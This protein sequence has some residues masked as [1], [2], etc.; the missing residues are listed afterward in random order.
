MSLDVLDRPQTETTA[1]ARPARPQPQ[2]IGVIDCDCHPT[3]RTIADLKPYLARRWWERIEAYGL[4]PRHAFVNGDPFPKAQPRAA[5]RDAWTPEGFQPGSDLAY[6]REHYLEPYNIDYAIL[7]PLYPTGQGD[8]DP[9]FTTAMCAAANDWQLDAW[10]HRDQRLKASILVSYEDAE[11]AVAEIEQRAGDKSFAQV[12]LLTRT[13]EPL[14]RKRYWPIYAAAERHGLPVAMHV[15]GYSGYPV[16][17]TGWP[18][19][20]LEEMTGHSAACQSAVTS[21]VLEGVFERF[22]DIRFVNIEGGFGWLAAL[23]WRLDKHWSRLRAEIPHLKRPP[24]E[25]LRRQLWITTQPMEEPENPQHLLDMM[26]QVGLDRLLFATDYPHWDFDDPAR[27]LPTSLTL[28][29]RKQICS[30]NAREL[31]RLD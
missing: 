8:Q 6:M 24:S 13:S 23:Q 26:E 5:R 2:R 31:Y 7:S 4:R 27:V 29:Q 17:G 30:G 15:F 25:Y 16:S 10:V 22:P 1:P 18:S 21:L 3:V 11:A 12:L 19:Y 20:Y 14:G 9:D 28:E